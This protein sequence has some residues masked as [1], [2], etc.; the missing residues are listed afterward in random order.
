MGSG[1]IVGPEDLG[2]VA[3][4]EGW[5]RTLSLVGSS[6]PDTQ[7]MGLTGRKAGL[8]CGQLLDHSSRPQGDGRGKVQLRQ[9]VSSPLLHPTVSC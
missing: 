2:L 8:R 7:E 9:E 5:A 4:E 3:G 6:F 1:N